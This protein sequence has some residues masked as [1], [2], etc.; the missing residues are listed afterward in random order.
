MSPGKNRK[1]NTVDE[2]TTHI[3]I[4]AAS[5]DGASIR[6]TS[7]RLGLA[8]ESSS[9]FVK[10]TN[11]FQA[12]EVINFAS[13]LIKEYCEGKDFS[14]IV[15]YQSEKEPNQKLNCSVKRI[16]NRLGTEFLEDDV[17]NVLER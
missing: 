9:R 17:V 3:Y 4:E 1:R 5:F 7:T 12:D 11:H 8:S 14:N 13:Y 15:T 10:G 16:N 6:H 2:K